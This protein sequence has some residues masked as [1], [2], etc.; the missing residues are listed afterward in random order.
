[1]ITFKHTLFAALAVFGLGA[2]AL[3]TETMISQKGKAFSIDEMTAA[4][5]DTVRI[6]NDD[7]IPHNVIVASPDGSS[8]NFGVQPPGS[9]AAISLNQVGD[10]SVRCGI[11]PKMKLAIHTR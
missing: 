10:Y 9:S 5:H 4:A 2:S 7:D 1:M 11:H 3:A 6:N 8:Q